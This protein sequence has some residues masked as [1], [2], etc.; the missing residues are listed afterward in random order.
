MQEASGAL[1]NEVTY[2]YN[3]FQQSTD[4]AQQH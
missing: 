4:E 1:V 2:T 3:N